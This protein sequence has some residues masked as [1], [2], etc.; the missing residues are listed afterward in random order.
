MSCL[1]LIYN[2]FIREKRKLHKKQEI[3]IRFVV[4]ARCCR[5]LIDSII[6]TLTRLNTH[7]TIQM[8]I[9]CSTKKM[10]TKQEKRAIF[11]VL[12]DKMQVL[13]IQYI[14]HTHACTLYYKTDNNSTNYAVRVACCPLKNL[15][16]Y[17]PNCFPEF[18]WII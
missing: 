1:A 7:Y 8:P 2:V 14:T 10:L 5:H 11:G 13:Y 16:T 4:V 12:S 6:C 9:S 17:D 18:G 3:A 15:N